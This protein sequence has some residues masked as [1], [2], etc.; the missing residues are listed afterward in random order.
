MT[1]LSPELRE[2]VLEAARSPSLPMPSRTAWRALV[3]TCGAVIGAAVFLAA[4]GLR[5]GPRP[6]A[7]LVTSTGVVAMTAALGTW[8]LMTRGRSMLGRPYGLRLAAMLGGLL[9]SIAGRYLPSRAVE[10]MI[11]PWPTRPGY[12]CFALALAVGLA[13]LVCM[14]TA[15]R[16]SDAVGPGWTGAGVGVAAG[17]SSGVLVDLWCPVAYL[18][19]LAL[20][21]ALPVVV[22][23]LYGAWLGRRLLATAL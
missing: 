2:R 10:G 16:R 5:L 12:R 8:V 23:A 11:V 7:L 3:L 14:V 19:H 9:A 1:G 15:L 20:G 13:P 22:F 18:P 4:G 17:L 6:M 21:H